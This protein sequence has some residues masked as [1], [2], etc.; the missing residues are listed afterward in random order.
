MYQKENCVRCEPRPRGSAS[1][2]DV[3]DLTNLGAAEFQSIAELVSR[4]VG[5][6]L[7]SG[8]RYLVASRL[9][10]RLRA[11]RLSNYRQYCEYL[12]SPLGQ[13]TELPYLKDL[14]TTHKTDFFRESD[15]FRVLTDEVVPQWLAHRK[16]SEVFSVWSAACSTGEEPYSVAM[17]LADHQAL[18]QQSR[19][20]FSVLGTDV[21]SDCV[22]T[23]KRAVYGSAQVDAIP[24]RL[25]RRFL[26]RSRDPSQPRFR[27][28]PALRARVRFH[29][30]NFID[31]A[32]QVDHFDVVFCRNVLIYF[33]PSMQRSILQRLCEHLKPGGHLFIG[34]SETLGTAVLPLVSVGRSSFRKQR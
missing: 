24:A 22:E 19:T 27:I 17:T 7:G 23:A 34:H 20:V 12:L 33:E 30:L 5:I 6:H 4:H 32:W 25:R 14:L 13:Q 3:A 1:P 9:L 18:A 8:K 26:L 16:G 10:R 11:L 15:H 21:S 2:A 31:Q 29:T 28:T